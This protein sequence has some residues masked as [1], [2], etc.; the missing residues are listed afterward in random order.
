MNESMR[1]ISTGAQPGA[2]LAQAEAYRHARRRVRMLQGW[3]VH[4]L[5]YVCVIGILWLVYGFSSQSRFPWPLPPMLGWGLGLAIHGLVVWLGTSRQ[6]RDWQSR[7]IE[8]YMKED[9][10]SRSCERR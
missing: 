3:Y 6:S 1:N 2:D 9:M 4:A 10:A 5:V 7:K 8:Q